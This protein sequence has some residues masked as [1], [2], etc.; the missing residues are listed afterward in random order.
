MDPQWVQFCR[1]DVNCSSTPS[2]CQ[3]GRPVGISTQNICLTHTRT[4]TH[5]TRPVTIGRC[6]PVSRPTWRSG[7]RSGV[8]V[9]PRQRRGDGGMSA[10]LLLQSSL[11]ARGCRTQKHTVWLGQRCTALGS[12]AAA[13]AVVSHQS[14][15]VA[16]PSSSLV[17]II[18]S[19]TG[20]HG[21]VEIEARP[22]VEG[23]WQ[24]EKESLRPSRAAVPSTTR[25]LWY[26]VDAL[27][28]RF[29]SPEMQIIHSFV[30]RLVVD[31]IDPQSISSSVVIYFPYNLSLTIFNVYI[32][33]LV[34]LDSFLH[35]RERWKHSQYWSSDSNLTS[36]RTQFL[37]F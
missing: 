11:L 6:R 10:L 2:W 22:A 18:H 15:R 29:F 5:L 35:W 25:P 33:L 13:V 14:S 30:K 1:Q 26:G 7:V 12:A 4:L 8:H 34:Q 17:W 20:T 21:W 28:S 23:R 37:S 16:A 27:M 31:L 9:Q 32:I 19:Q 24:E 3:C 36:N